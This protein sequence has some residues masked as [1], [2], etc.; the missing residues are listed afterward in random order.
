MAEN[1]LPLLLRASYAIWANKHYL[2]KRRILRTTPKSL[3]VIQFKCLQP[4]LARKHVGALC[5]LHKKINLA[6][7]GHVDPSELENYVR[8]NVQSV[9][10][11]KSVFFNQIFALPNNDWSFFMMKLNP[12]DF[13][14][15]VGK[16]ISS[17]F[18]LG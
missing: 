15:A 16:N 8:K 1:P 4:P 18:Q 7:S 13:V 9:E 2:R 3:R 5:D 11:C 6:R 12:I 14:Q 17:S 10:I